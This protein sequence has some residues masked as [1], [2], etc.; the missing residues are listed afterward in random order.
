MA[1]LL[2]PS[3]TLSLSL[4]LPKRDI[5]TDRVARYAHPAQP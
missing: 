5:V 3:V 4:S 1:S 2:L